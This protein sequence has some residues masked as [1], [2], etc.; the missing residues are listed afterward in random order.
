MAVFSLRRERQ[1]DLCAREGLNFRIEYYIYS[2]SI[3][4]L[5][6]PFSVIFVVECDGVWYSR[7]FV[8][9]MIYNIYFSARSENLI[10]ARKS[11]IY[12]SD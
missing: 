12:I 11:C 2:R 3:S 7:D 9:C 5:F 1:T 4:L 8:L 10:L 6:L